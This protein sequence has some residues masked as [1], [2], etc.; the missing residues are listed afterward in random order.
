MATP[1]DRLTDPHDC[2]ELL[3]EMKPKNFATY[4]DNVEKM[5]GLLRLFDKTIDVLECTKVDAESTGDRMAQGMTLKQIDDRLAECLSEKLFIQEAIEFES[6]PGDATFSTPSECK[7][8]DMIDDDRNLITIDNSTYFDINCKNC[9]LINRVKTDKGNKRCD[10]CSSYVLP[11]NLEK[12][13]VP[14]AISDKG[15]EKI[16]YIDLS[17]SIE[18]KTHKERTLDNFKASTLPVPSAIDTSYNAFLADKSVIMSVIDGANTQHV[19]EPL[20]EKYKTLLHS[21]KE[22]IYRRLLWFDYANNTLLARRMDISLIGKNKQYSI[23]LKKHVNGQTPQL[24]ALYDAVDK[25]K[26]MV[27]TMYTGEMIRV[28]APD[29][30]AYDC[31]ILEIQYDGRLITAHSPALMEKL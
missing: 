27:P 12:D 3:D 4:K 6:Y 9:G 28:I 23:M 14:P 20:H 10:A 21:E 11:V 18:D 7:S 1:I 24:R 30:D 26:S 17:T 16:T 22:F 13:G 5:K 29:P 2:L 15:K 19:W 25:F 8:S 31:T